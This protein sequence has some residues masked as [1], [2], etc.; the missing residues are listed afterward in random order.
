MVIPAFISL[1]LAESRLVAMNPQGYGPWPSLLPRPPSFD[2]IMLW[3]NIS[4][5]IALATGI[6]S[7]PRWQSLVGLC[8]TIFY[9]FFIYWSFA[10]H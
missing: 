10:T 3:R 1:V 6:I 9:S 4:F 2:R 7:L 5:I 8:L